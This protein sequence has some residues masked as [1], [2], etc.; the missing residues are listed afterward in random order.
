M[1]TTK[2]TA[3]PLPPPPPR[4][5]CLFKSHTVINS[6]LWRLRLCPRILS[7]MLSLSSVMMTSR[8]ASGVVRQGQ[9]RHIIAA[10]G[11]SSSGGGGGEG[12]HPSHF[13][14]A[15]SRSVYSVSALCSL[16]SALCSFASQNADSHFH[17]KAMRRR[18]R[19][20]RR[21]RNRNRI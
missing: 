1:C 18:T 21:R 3:F 5:S 16:L 8:E 6:G 9:D 10:A 14:L 20:R 15:G 7:I 12:L 13:L 19:R 4:K 2:S 11:S 17:S